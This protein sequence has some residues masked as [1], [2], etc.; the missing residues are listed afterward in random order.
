[1]PS[2]SPS[3][4][5]PRSLR[6]RANSV[7]ARGGRG[8]ARLRLSAVSGG[9]DNNFNLLRFLAAA[10]VILTH[11]FYFTAHTAAE[12]FHR[13]FNR[14][15]GDAGVDAFFVLSGFLVTKSW[16]E[17]SLPEFAWARCMRIYPG[18]WASVLLT[19]LLAGLFFAAVPALQFWLSRDTLAYIAHNTL[20][21]PH[22]G[23]R[24]RLTHAL[25]GT[26]AAFNASLWTLPL[27]IEM[28]L[29]LA[30]LGVVFGVRARYAAALALLGVA[31]VV[32]GRLWAAENDMLI[33]HGRFLYFFFIGSLAWLLRARIALSSPAAL[34][35]MGA[36]LV[37]LLL[38]PSFAARQVALALALPY[39][40]LWFAYVP[41]GPIRAWNRLGDYSYGLYI[42]SAPI[43]LAV[44]TLGVGA[45]PAVNFAASIFIAL[46]FAIA[47]WHLI[48]RPALH[49][50]LPHSL[51]RLRIR[52]PLLLMSRLVR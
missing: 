18:L 6:P 28:Y 24:L 21:L 26:T 7:N 23:A 35:L 4:P 36:V 42:Y 38:T 22:F 50:P 20:M 30:V 27:E 48:E 11:A 37:T 51:A 3:Q 13:L 12:P 34:A 43:Q 19:V 10:L 40:L 2:V 41:A 5:A 8:Q 44:A 15:F 49:R 17:R 52:T 39:L 31:F 33:A 47:S 1:M 16:Q 14:G 9:R 25:R 29:T 45:T 46:T 32:A